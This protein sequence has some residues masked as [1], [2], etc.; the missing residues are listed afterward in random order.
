LAQAVK[1]EPDIIGLSGLLTSSYD[2]MKETIKLIRTAGEANLSAIP[3][4]IGGNQLNSQ[5]CNYVGVD[6]WVND[7]MAGVRICQQIM[8]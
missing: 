7:A 3:I 1:T 2:S 6:H 4:I 8:D 5:V